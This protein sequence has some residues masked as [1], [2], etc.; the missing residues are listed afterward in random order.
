MRPSPEATSPRRGRPRSERSRQAVLRAANEL[1]QLR[2]LSGVSVD[3]IAARAGVSKATIYRWWSSKEEVALEAFLTALGGVEALSADT[4]SLAGDL[5]AGMRARIRLLTQEPSL[6]RTHAGLVARGQED[7]AF[8]ESYHRLVMAPLRTHAR[9][10]FQRA[11]GRG[12]IPA[13][14]DVD[15]ALDLLFGAIYHRLWQS[16]GRLGDRFARTCVDIVVRGLSA[17]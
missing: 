6:A 1:L 15:T 3:E 12:E 8:A 4:G 9:E 2:G 11:I 17:A 13:G 5:L 10:V 7:P 14:A 16:Y